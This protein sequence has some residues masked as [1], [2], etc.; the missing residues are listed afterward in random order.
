M[1]P[2]QLGGMLAG[3]MLGSL[4]LACDGAVD[5]T[6]GT[7]LST[8]PAGTPLSAEPAGAAQAPAAVEAATPGPERSNPS[9][10][11]A[12]LLKELEAIGYVEA[13]PA[14]RPGCE[15]VTVHQP[16][17]VTPGYNLF[18]RNAEALLLSNAGEIVHRW[19][20]GDR[21]GIAFAEL[22]AD[23]RLIAGYR[24]ALHLLGWKGK[25]IWKL[26]LWVHH[27]IEPRADGTFLVLYKEPVEFQGR[28]VYFDGIAHISADGRVLS[29]WFQRDHLRELHQHHGR[30]ALDHP[31]TRDPE[32][33]RYDYYHTNSLE[34][35]PETPLGVVDPRFR[36]G[37]LLLCLH[38]V[39]R[40]YILDPDDHE[41][42]WTWGGDELDLPHMPTLL[43]SGNLLIYDNG[44]HRGHSRILEL[45]P[46]TEE[47][48]WSYEGRP[49][50]AFFSEFRGSSQ[51]LPGGNTLICE[52]ERGHAFEVT[53][54]G[55]LVWEYWNPLEEG[56]RKSMYR[57]IRHDEAAVERLL[58]R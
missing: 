18:T 35:L 7:A 28:L 5:E 1:T 25:L 57:F 53:A 52:A 10:A 11:D 48:V 29:R 44:T 8:E 14:T 54:D 55:T 4:L 17:Q 37:N 34:I 3:G 51:R 27:D 2:I 20:L 49:R 56:Q 46:R 38:K 39:N 19:K 31:G 23:G 16:D 42:L 45:D 47:I 13:S 22:L 26:D 36:A 15:G 32:D 33:T 21:G 43:A 50:E 30:T 41:V 12:D 58:R 24:K 9:L 6:Q 40:I